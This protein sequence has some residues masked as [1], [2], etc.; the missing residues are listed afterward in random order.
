[1]RASRLEAFSDG[2]LAI[3]ITIMVLEIHAPE[4]HELADWVPLIPIV[5]AYLFSFTFIAIYWNNH[6]HL[7][8]ATNHITPS[9]MWTNMLLLFFLSLIPVAT[10]WLGENEN[11]LHTWPVVAYAGVSLFAGLAFYL[12][13]RRIVKANPN[14][15]RLD[16]FVASRKGAAS[17]FLYGGAIVVAFFIPLAGI[18]LLVVSAALW[19]IPDRTLVEE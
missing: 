15:A 1:M 5:L 14:D 12:L 4:G 16:A 7:L 11:Y 19:F 18:A 3:I 17:P 10:A 6:H 2:V 8:R 9:V 13:T